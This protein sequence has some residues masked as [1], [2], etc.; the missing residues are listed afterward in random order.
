MKTSE[1]VFELVLLPSQYTFTKN[2]CFP[3]DLDLP[4]AINDPSVSADSTFVQRTYVRITDADSLLWA[5]K[6]VDMKLYGLV[7]RSRFFLFDL[8]DGT[9]Y[10]L[11]KKNEHVLIGKTWS[12]NPE[13]VRFFEKELLRK[14][15]PKQLSLLGVEKR[16]L[17]I[18]FK[19]IPTNLGAL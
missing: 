15:K 11:Y 2:L 4:G 6:A 1:V 5:L 16:K 9:F 8:T 17:D 12:L 13:L 10:S 3:E 14:R 7:G 19:G 18:V